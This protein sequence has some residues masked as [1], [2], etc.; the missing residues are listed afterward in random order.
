MFRV[1]P[2]EIEIDKYVKWEILGVLKSINSD[3]ILTD[4]II[5][6]K[7]LQCIQGDHLS[8]IVQYDGELLALKLD[9]HLHSKEERDRLKMKETRTFALS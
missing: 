3:P 7:L 4:K 8:I 2:F 9:R 1:N 6:A 5:G